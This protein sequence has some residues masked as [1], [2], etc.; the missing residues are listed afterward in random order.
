MD[1]KPRRAT[2]V[3]VIALSLFLISMPLTLLNSHGPGWFADSDGWQGY[4]IVFTWTMVIF[5]GGWFLIPVA[6]SNAY[7]ICGMWLRLPMWIHFAAW[8]ICWLSLAI[9]LTGI[10]AY[11]AFTL[12]AL[13]WILSGI[14]PIL[15]WRCR[16]DTDEPVSQPAVTQGDT[17]KL[18]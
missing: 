14:G 4:D 17:S 2:T 11:P 7:V 16:V 10:P 1:P 18:S 3:R 15:D 8:A 12:L 13:S 6:I 9:V 5:F